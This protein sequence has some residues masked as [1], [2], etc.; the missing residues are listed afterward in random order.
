VDCRCPS[1]E[2]VGAWFPRGD[3]A[4]SFDEVDLARDYMTDPSA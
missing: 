2:I 1:P 4:A 3:L